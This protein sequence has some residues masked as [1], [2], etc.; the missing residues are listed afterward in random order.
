MVGKKSCPLKI[1][2]VRGRP[3]PDFG[4]YFHLF[5]ATTK[6]CSCTSA[7]SDGWTLEV[8]MRGRCC[9]C[10]IWH[11]IV[12]RRSTFKRHLTCHYYYA[13]WAT[14][15]ILRWSKVKM[16]MRIYWMEPYT[17][18]ILRSVGSTDTFTLCFYFNTKRGSKVDIAGRK[19]TVRIKETNSHQYF[20]QTHFTKMNA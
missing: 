6:S 12:I 14:N 1:L 5:C 18:N 8:Q 11:R 3:L 4:T 17:L 2:S 16:L 19:R 13:Q 9:L 15:W 20:L 10:K 7:T